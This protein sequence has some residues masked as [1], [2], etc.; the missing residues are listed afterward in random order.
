[1]PLD[2]AF[3]V[4]ADNPLEPPPEPPPIRPAT[5]VTDEK[6]YD[7]DFSDA[8]LN[9]FLT[10][11]QAVERGDRALYASRL[12][13]RHGLSMGTALQVADNR[14]PLEAAMRRKA[15]IAAGER[16][17]VKPEAA[18]PLVS[19][20]GIAC[21]A[22]VVVVCGAAAWR[23]ASV[24]GGGDAEPTVAAARPVSSSPRAP[25][26]PQAATEIHLDATGRPLAV[27]APDPD[28]VLNAF[29][30]STTGTVVRAPEKVVRSGEEYVGYYTEAGIRYA[31]RIHKEPTG[32]SAGTVAEPI[33]PED[34]A[35]K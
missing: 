16:H 17:S 24:R 14:I 31:L 35:R 1:M 18:K 7:A 26:V 27:K 19:R 25:V 5:P 23:V 32:Y 10:V 22:V 34:L 30:G 15:A 13:T 4:R 11:R 28:S 33:R 6:P 2:R 21:A 20:L 9:G 8:V 29:C 3:S 12:A